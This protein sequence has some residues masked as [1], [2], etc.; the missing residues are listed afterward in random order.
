MRFSKYIRLTV[1]VLLALALVSTITHFSGKGGIEGEISADFVFEIEPLLQAKCQSCHGADPTDISGGLNLT[2]RAGLLSGGRSGSAAVVPGNS[3]A[4][5]LVHVIKRL[6]PET[7]MPPKAAE[8]LSAEEIELFSKWIDGGA[9]WPDG[10][11]KKAILNDPQWKG[12][13]R[14]VIPSQHALNESWSNKAYRLEDLWAYQPLP[15]IDI[16]SDR[17]P[18]DYLIDLELD[19]L[20]LPKAPLASREQLAR[21]LYFDLTGLPPTYQQIRKF[22]ETND[23]SYYN[24]LVDSLLNQK[25]YGEK[26]AQFWLDLV[27][28]ADSDGFSNDYIRPNAWRY[29]DYV[30]RSFNEDKP[31]DQFIREQIAG[32][33]MDPQ[34]PEMAVATGFLRMGPWEHTAMSVAKETRQLFLDDVVNSVGETFLSTPLMCAKCHDHKFDPISSYDYY[35]LQAV[36]ATTQFADQPAAFLPEENLNFMQEEKKRMNWWI[37]RTR[38]ELDELYAREEAAAHQWYEERGKKYLSKKERRK[39]PDAEQPPRYL[40]L[41]NADLGYRKVLQKRFQTLNAE[42]RKFMPLAFS[43]YDGSDR[44]VFSGREM[45]KPEETEDSLPRTYLLQA[46]SVFSPLQ[47][48]TPGVLQAISLIDQSETDQPDSALAPEI[49]GSG[50]GRRLALA[51]WITNANHPL[52]A[53]SIVNRIWQCHFGQGLTEDPNNFGT[54]SRNPRLVDLINFL[55]HYLISNNWSLKK[56]NTLI[57][58]SETFQRSCQPALESSQLD[59]NNQ[60]FAHFNPRRLG[61]EEIRDAILYTS[62]ELNPASG[63]IPARPEINQE[64]ALQPRHIMGSVAQAYQPNRTRSERNRRTVYTERIRSLENPFLTVF[65][66]PSTEIPCGHRSISTISPQA[67]ALFNSDQIRK[68]ALALSILVSRSNSEIEQQIRTAIQKVWLREPV[69]EEIDQARRYMESMVQYHK[70]I[71]GS[72]I[73]RPREVV[74]EMFEE[75]TG[76]S[77]SFR[78]PLDIYS[79]Y[80][81]DPQ[82]AEVSPEVRAL[83]DYCHIL[84][85][86]NEFVYV[87]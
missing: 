19:K 36:F 84:F 11:A 52:T 81:E 85:N 10:E 14:I 27:R 46:G 72:R 55:A 15:D 35:S 75:M 74:R 54:A 6:D 16:P 62:G 30:I 65:N 63:G 20:G 22:V 57:L 49:T 73:E 9:P 17:N 69:G 33:E 66:R 12:K 68:Q 41:S 50:G 53:R 37:D 61:A 56:L 4:S 26:F 25:T 47:E 8:R 64:V 58:T 24:K 67:L 87:Y 7:A 5:T 48:V 39:L 31:F 44:I 51:E 2:T 60:F 78:E 79:N 29:R 59:P 80:E 13:G 38:K 86:S 40:G 23:S 43:V 42:Q 28:Y 34:D 82:Y 3:E 70:E 1:F 21:R 32:D 77:F 83:A 18:I 45:N 71:P 76:E